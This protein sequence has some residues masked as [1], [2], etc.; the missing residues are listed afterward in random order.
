[1]LEVTPSGKHKRTR[2]SSEPFAE[3][4]AL[5]T[6]QHSVLRAWLKSHAQERN[7]QSLL[8]AAG[9]SHLDAAQELLPLLLNA[10]AVAVKEELVHTQWRPWRVVWTDLDALQR[11]AGIA[12]RTERQ[13][14]RCRWVEQLQALAEEHDWLAAAV[15]SCLR[16][17]LSAS[18]QAARTELLIALVQWKQ[19]ERQGLRQDFALAARGHTKALTATE[20]DWLEQHVPMESLGI[21]RFE[22][23]LYLGGA[24]GLRDAE[25]GA[26]WR[27]DATGF[28]ALPC[29]KLAAPLTVCKVPSHYWLIENRASF[30]RQVLRLDSDVCIVWLPGR[31]GHDWQ[32]AM[33]WLLQAAPAP[34]VISCD[35]DPAGIQIALTA[36]AL[37][38]AA[39]LSWR[40]DR[41]A[42]QEWLGGATLPLN[43]YDLRVLEALEH[44]PLPAELATLRDALLQHRCKAEQEG[45]L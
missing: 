38:H 2:R 7:W 34:A 32:T 8:E 19:E 4:P 45:W 16:G 28:V 25:R 22:P 9:V 20:W 36:G 12:T 11:A 10:G 1:M 29:R 15:Q 44:T 27:L 17:Q 24:L 5:S 21:A 30:E 18:A 31:P 23:L 13:A 3:L 39:G 6:A 14:D 41:M 43:A 26:Q 40:A 35:P 33:R 37:W 42:P